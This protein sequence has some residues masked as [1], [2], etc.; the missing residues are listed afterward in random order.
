MVTDARHVVPIIDAT[1]YFK[2]KNAL[3]LPTMEAF[4]KQ[5]GQKIPP[6]R[7]DEVL[8]GSLVTVAYTANTYNTDQAKPNLS[9][10]LHA[11]YV[12]A[13]VE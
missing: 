13:D 9:L 7:R 10:N 1:G 12:L 11:V 3:A 8:P 6:R 2:K 4:L 5:S